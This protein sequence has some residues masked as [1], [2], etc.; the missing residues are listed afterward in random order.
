M[1]AAWLFLAGTLASPQQW[2]AQGS[3]TSASL[4]A[5]SAAGAKIV[6]AG[7]TRGSYLRTL[8][9]GRNWTAAQ[10]AG[11]GDLDFRGVRAFDA[12]TV[13]LMSAGEGAM[14]RVYKT[15]DG[16]KSWRLQ[17]TNP[18]ARGFFDCIAFRNRERGIVVGDP[19]DGDFAIF[20]TVDGGRNWRRRRGPRALRQEG[21]FA[22]SNSCVFAAG[23]SDVWFVS[24]GVGGARVFHSRDGGAEWETGGT[25][26]RS[27]RAS[28][29]IFSVF[30][31]DQKHGAIA[32]GDYAK[33]R[34]PSGSLEVT[35]DGGRTW[36]IPER[37]P[38]GFRSAVAYLAKRRIWI[39]TGTSGS[40]V[41]RDGGQ[42]WTGFDSGSY[43]ALAV[44]GEDAWAVGAGGRIARLRR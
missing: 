37:A 8:D 12:D 26:M 11:A 39:A 25:A 9:G 44:S 40:D 14:S 30:F 22:A 28:A 43:N 1:K 38:A 34:E 19:V 13:F 32:G 5:V 4:R 20:T 41:S 15:I 10:V 18:D 6:W 3:H 21:A 23:A 27:D 2:V 36:R 35:S 31:S 7:G 29:G 16:G 33:D 17:L 42:T 24:G